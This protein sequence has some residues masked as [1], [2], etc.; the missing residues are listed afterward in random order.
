MRG[1]TLACLLSCCG[2]KIF[3]A[4]PTTCLEIAQPAAIYASVAQ[5][6][7]DEFNRQ[8]PGSFSCDSPE[9]RVLL[10]ETQS[11][12]SVPAGR[13]HARYDAGVIYLCD[14]ISP[15]WYHLPITITHEIG[16]YYG[17]PH[18]QDITNVMHSPSNATVKSLPES[19]TQIL[20]ALHHE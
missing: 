16:H 1:V 3:L 8:A 10:L 13:C 2:S 15:N 19:V 11:P 6:V 7:Q 20:E 17:L 14:T 4:Q 9:S 5:Q 18:S 12:D